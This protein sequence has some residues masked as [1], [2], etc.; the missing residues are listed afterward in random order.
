MSKILSLLLGIILTTTTIYDYTVTTIDGNSM[1]LAQ[2]KGKK[3][4][5]VNTSSGSI[6]SSQYGSLEQL[7]QKYKDSLIIIAIPS[8]SF[9]TEPGDNT[10]IKQFVSSTYNTHFIITQKAAVA[11]DG[12][13]PLYNWLTHITQN[14]M[15][16]DAVGGDFY[17]YLVDSSGRLVGAFISTV[18]PMSDEVQTA[19]TN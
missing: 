3:I 17:K 6:Y 18:D 15:M 4:L 14:G 10:Q 7:Y 8:N 16:G 12:Q 1:S 5:F 11:G 19:I 13:L 2:Y 9:G